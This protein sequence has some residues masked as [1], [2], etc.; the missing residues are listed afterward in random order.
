MVNKHQ[1]HSQVKTEQFSLLETILKKTN[2]V[3]QCRTDNPPW[4]QLGQHFINTLNK[5]T[6]S[7]KIYNKENIFQTFTIFHNYI[8]LP[9]QRI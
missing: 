1:I 8:L 3:S 7:K 6:T 2:H 4:L 5:G 9:I